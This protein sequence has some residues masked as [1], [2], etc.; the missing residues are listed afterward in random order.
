MYLGILVVEHIL[1][2]YVYTHTYHASTLIMGENRC[3]DNSVY[4]N[5]IINNILIMNNIMNIIT[6]ITNNNKQ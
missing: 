5:N 2:I 3:H 4:N 6:A 1:D